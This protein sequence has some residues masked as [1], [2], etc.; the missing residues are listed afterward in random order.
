MN[1][2]NKQFYLL[3]SYHH[4]PPLLVC[5]SVNPEH[6]RA[7]FRH[8]R[9]LTRSTIMSQVFTSMGVKI[10]QRQTR[11]NTISV[12]SSAHVDSWA[13]AGSFSFHLH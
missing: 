11:N 4:H 7:A 3:F 1:H 6:P 5:F 10:N 9:R 13:R 8:A 12:F 2:I